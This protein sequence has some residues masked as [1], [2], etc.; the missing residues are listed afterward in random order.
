[1]RIS[2]TREEIDY[3]SSIGIRRQRASTRRGDTDYMSRRTDRQTA[4]I[5]G[6]CGEYAAAK[7]LFELAGIELD[8]NRFKLGVN[9]YNSKPDV[10]VPGVG[11][12]EIK[13][14]RTRPGDRYF[15]MTFSGKDLVSK[16]EPFVLIRMLDRESLVDWEIVGWCSTDQ[17]CDLLRDGIA[18]ATSHAPGHTTGIFVPGEALNPIQEFF[19]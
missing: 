11:G 16:D 5:Q 7:V 19:P 9:T 10:A 17:A 12:F 1:M 4:D 2:L 15:G 3:A 13:S 18:S 6:A 14:T 8:P